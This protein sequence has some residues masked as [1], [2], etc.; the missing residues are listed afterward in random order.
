MVKTEFFKARSDGVDL[1]RTYST[2]GL[3]LLQ[4]ETGTVYSE[5]VDVDGAAYTYTEIEPEEVD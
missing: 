2:E 4:V 1:Y 3:D 5:A